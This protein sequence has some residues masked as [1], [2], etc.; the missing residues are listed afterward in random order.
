ML[1]QKIKTF[2]ALFSVLILALGSIVIAYGGASVKKPL[3]NADVTPKYVSD[4]FVTMEPSDADGGLMSPDWLKSAI[5]VQMRIETATKEGNLEAAVKILDHY[6]EAGINCLW[7]APV[8]HKGQSLAMPNGYTS[9]GL[10]TIDPSITGTSNYD[11]GWESFAWF[12]REA[13]KRNIRILLDFI[14]WG[15]DPLSPLVKSNP[16]FFAGMSDWGGPSYDIENPKFLNW[17][18]STAVDIVEKTN[19]DGFRCDLEPHYTGYGMYGEI[20]KE[21]LK[22]GHKIAIMSESPNERGETYDLEQFGVMKHDDWG[23]GKEILDPQDYFLDHYNIVD[24]VKNGTGIGS[25][26]SQKLDEGANARFYTYMF[27]CHDHGW[28]SIESDLIRVG[29]QGIFSPF[30]PLWYMGEEIGATVSNATLYYA[31]KLDLEELDLPENRYFFETLKK[32]IRIRRTYRSIFENFP[33]SLRDSNICKV[34]VGG[35]EKYQAY[36]RFDDNGN[37]VIIVP[38][39]NIQDKN[40]AMKVFVP[41]KDMNMLN[42]KSYEITDLMTD[43]KITSGS[44]EN[45]GIFDVTVPQGELGVY[46]V[47]AKG[48]INTP[49]LPQTSSQSDTSSEDNGELLESNVSTASE[50]NEASKQP[51]KTVVNEETEEIR[52]IDNT[53]MWIILGVMA[54]LIIAAGAYLT[55]III[56][57]G[58]TK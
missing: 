36:A 37:G 29:Y 28:T 44:K 8:Q 14:V 56:K 21:L 4:K 13:H 2:T 24:A 38:N 49:A 19:I 27:S 9:Y 48:K 51:G 32:Y 18:K 41:F 43:K 45:A 55:I 42:Y 22:K 26:L 57:K 34:D 39:A 15:V 20:R 35:L 5:M 53:V 12:V 52:N 58:K 50:E 33:L 3:S 25:D 47:K 40:A 17:Y 11:E 16:E 31:M 1:K 30:I 23:L 6:Q 10:H 46:L 54:A 7:I